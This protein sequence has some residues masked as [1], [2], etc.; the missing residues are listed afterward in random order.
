MFPNL[1][2]QGKLTGIILLTSYAVLV[3]AGV[4]FV[5]YERIAF[6][7]VM[8]N[9]LTT[10]AEIV[11]NASTAGLSFNDPRPI[12]ETLA[13]LSA[14][15]HLIAAIV[16]DESRRI[17]AQYVRADHREK[18]SA[19]PPEERGHHI[20]RNELILH[21]PVTLNG[22]RL[23]TVVLHRDFAEQDA[24]LRRYVLI[25]T[26]LLLGSLPFT[27]LLASRLQRVIS[28]PVSHLAQTAAAVAAEKNYSLRAVKH[29]ED[30]LGR[31]IDNFNEMIAQ[32][33]ARDTALQSAHDDLEKR[34]ADRTAELSRSISELKN[35]ETALRESE[36]RF[37]TVFEGSP[38]AFFVE[39]AAGNVVDCN[40][41]A[42]RLQG[43][44]QAELL[45]KNVRDLVPPDRREETARNFQK[46]VSGELRL[47]EGSTL[48]KDGKIVPVEVRS[49]PVLFT[50]QP[51]VLLQVRDI[52]ERHSLEA[53]VRHAQKMEAV[54]QLAAGV[55]HDFNNILTVIQGHTSLLLDDHALDAESEAS[56]REIAAS[57]TRAANLTRQLLTFSR[58]QVMQPRPLDLGAVVADAMKMLRRLLGETIAVELERAPALPAVL[59]DTSMMEQIILNLVMNSRDALPGGGRIVVST[60]AVELDAARAAQNPDARAGRFVC[61]RVTD[62]GTG[63]DA[64][65]RARIFEPF[66]TTK[67]VGKGTGLGLATVYGI[68]KQHQGW[69]EVASEPGRGATFRIFLPATARPSEAAETPPSPDTRR[70][71]ETIFVVED[72]PALRDLVAGLLRN[73]GYHVITAVSGRD[74]LRL[75]RE[76]SPRVDLLLTDMMMPDGVSGWELAKQL[77]AQAPKLK[78]IYTS[79]Y[80]A[81]LFANQVELEE[82]V[83]FL[84]K[85]YQPRLLA[86]TVR[87]CLDQPEV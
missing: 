32:I 31:L 29:G 86:Q 9:T 62:N 35:A 72:E 64:A 28:G 70:G 47:T 26:V 39:D 8:L 19:P 21:Q 78:I 50:G 60:A 27:Y 83:N 84:S 1:S 40:P 12:V 61:L 63:M 24:R 16:F 11:A 5:F 57:A 74:A 58:K 43:M 59:A 68:V 37:R 42:C 13:S 67:D 52:A 75:W 22:Q 36:T 2:L 44:E 14:D 4:A 82:G 53:Q 73:H 46:L 34:V 25:V 3:T 17:V 77:R 15:T 38:D 7:A 41:A 87:N 45:G 71:A 48:T 6:R 18:Y 79:G 69:I 56:L 81:D 49:A 51:C 33:Q 80:S 54:G 30:E 10:R 23:G 85:P 20:E 55:A 76:Q 66:F 65:T